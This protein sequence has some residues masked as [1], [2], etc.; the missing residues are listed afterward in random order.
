V[1]KTDAIFAA[2][3]HQTAQQR[4]MLRPAAMAGK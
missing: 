3:P 1:G 2:M 4:R